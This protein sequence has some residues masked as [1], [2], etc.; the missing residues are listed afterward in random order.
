MSILACWATTNRRTD[1]STE[2][3]G[4]RALA[5][6]RDRKSLPSSVYPREGAGR[7]ITA[8]RTLKPVRKLCMWRQSWAFRPIRP[9]RPANISSRP[10]R[11]PHDIGGFWCLA[12]AMLCQG[13][14]RRGVP[15]LLVHTGGKQEGTGLAITVRPL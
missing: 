11:D 5:V 4:R 7:D 1:G 8:F 14:K 2:H 3:H 9:K 10:S 12:T 13:G 15:G 6:T